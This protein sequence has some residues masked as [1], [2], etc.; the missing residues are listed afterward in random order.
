MRIS[1]SVILERRDLE[2]IPI[3]LN[4]LFGVMA[5]LVPAIH[6]FPRKARKKDV[7]AR[8]VTPRRVTRRGV[9]A[10]A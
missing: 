9:T 1:A 8:A 5:G 6:V 2:R 3:M 4:H 7:D 10:R